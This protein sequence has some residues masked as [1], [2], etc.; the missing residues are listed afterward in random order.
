MIHHLLLILPILT[1][2]AIAFSSQHSAK[3]IAFAGSTATFIAGA[4]FAV[5]FPNWST[6]GFWPN[7]GSTSI[8]GSFGVDLKIGVDSVSMLLVLLTVFLTPLSIAGSFS[9]I[10]TRQRE[11]YAWFMVLETSML[12]AFMSRDLIFFYIGYEFTLI[13]MFFLISIWG[14]PMR[15]PAA[16]KFFIFTFLG[17]VFTLTAVIF[18]AVR[19]FESAGTWTFGI[20]ELVKFS[21]TQLS[22][23]EQFWVF[24]GLIVGFAIKTPFFPTHSWLPLAHDQAPTGGSVILA[25]VL[26]KLG[27]YGVFRFALPMSPIGAVEC[28]TFFAIL[29]IIAILYMSL[30]CWVQTDIKKLIAYSSV[31]HMGFVVLGLFALNPIGLQGAVMYMVNHGLSTGALF[32]CIGMI[33]ER[34]HTKDMEQLGGL[35]ARMPV[36]S[37]FMIVFTLSSVGL[38]GLNGFIGEFLCLMGAFVAEHD[39]PAGYPGVLGPWY[40][41]IAAIG[42]ILGAMYL[43]IMLGKIVWGPLREPHGDGH[44]GHHGEHAASELPR[45]L[46][47][48]EIAIL[49]PI[50]LVC[51]AIGLY[52]QP[53]LNAVEPNVKE[54]LASFPKVIDAHNAKLGTPNPNKPTV[55]AE[56]PR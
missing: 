53:I 38:P 42:L 31:S 37:F 20:E 19:H 13:P 41:V 9:A 7:E 34:Y 50:A 47:F 48:R 8:L 3:W 35:V 56:A 25:G 1:A 39:Q 27:T 2:A 54:T 26:L 32:L 51:L 5:Q 33:Y 12:L 55:H 14:G 30:V 18:V 24:V 23:R 11:Y 4:V 45:D 10:R 46:N 15:G 6:G 43:L 28:S 22:D 16:I 44:A 29:G 52:P 21:S 36:W 17:S 49:A 40:A